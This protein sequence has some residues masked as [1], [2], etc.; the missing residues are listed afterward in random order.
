MAE[1][2]L[3]QT[4]EQQDGATGTSGAPDQDKPSP[5]GPKN[6]KLPD[7][8]KI[9]AKALLQLIKDRD[10]FDR[11]IEVLGDRKRRFYSDGIQHFYADYGTGFYQVGQTGGYIDIGDRHIECPD[12]M[13]DYNIFY[14][15]QRSLEAV[16]T[17]NPPGI[18]FRA[19]DPSHEEDIQAAEAAE[20]YRLKFDRANSAKGIQLKLS[21]MFCLSGRTVLEVLTEAN[22]QLWGNNPD[23][24]PK[25]ME[26]AKV[27]GT[28]ET[29]VP[30]FA[31]D[32]AGCMYTLL[33]DDPDELQAK[34]D[35]PQI[36]KKIK[37]GEGSPAETDYERWARLGVRQPKKTNYIKGFKYISTRTKAYLRPGMYEASCCDELWQSAE[38][39]APPEPSDDTVGVTVRDVLLDLYPQGWCFTFV[40]DTYAEGW[41]AN[42]DESIVI[43][44][45]REGDGM[46]GRAL[47]EGATVVQDSYN[48]KKNA[49]RQ[50]YEKG[51]PATWVDA[52][53]VDYDALLSQASEP[54]AFHEVKEL[55]KGD[56]VEAHIYREPEMVLSETFIQ[57]MEEDRG[58]LIQ[59][60]TG[61]LPT[62]QG[63][64][65]PTDKTATGKAI[66]RSQAMGMLSMA[67]AEMQRMLARMYYLAAI[68]AT[69][70]KDHGATITVPNPNG[71]NTEFSL[72]ALDKG[73]FTAHPDTDSSFPESTASKRQM[74]QAMLPLIANNPLGMEFFNNP[75]NWEEILQLLGSPELTL[76]PAS[77]YRK[78]T[79]EI[80]DLLE[81]EPNIPTA[82]DIAAA[83]V[84]HAKIAL[85]A[86]AKGLPPPPFQ[87]PVPTPSIGVGQFD[88]HKW[89]FL[90][91]QSFL[92]SERARR[93]KAQGND[94][95]LQNVELHAALHQQAMQAQEM[96]QAALAAPPPPPAA[97]G[98]PGRPPAG[99]GGAP[100]VPEATNPAV[101]RAAAPPVAT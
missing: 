52:D 15:C 10:Q 76:D 45:P 17:Q 35:H 78:Q 26:T 47:M 93:E 41:D 40:G 55:P 6:E 87:P 57:S 54:Y 61:A 73:N 71:P 63:E 30:I 72:A 92:S 97:P 5:F 74:L 42:F 84:A 29:K 101:A 99:H 85:E 36:R 13:D 89:E 94:K 69:R 67:W 70:N 86:E 37:G 95:G 7:Q 21:R 48:D 34:V 38:G 64:T 100:H 91:C 2:V 27:Y 65:S 12:Y 88:F 77:A 8:L 19:D 96:A 1:E 56:S 14:P 32:Q 49:E 43:G 50:A 39:Y 46:S 53:V 24:S 3:D 82:Q 22:A 66:D 83:Q 33:F 60:I 59:T 18:D 31:K 98:A 44:F 16:L 90:K 25:H 75:D 81:N 4:D 20:G 58:P 62:L 23:G 80:E 51:W 79:A 9:V 11:R 28:L 68:W